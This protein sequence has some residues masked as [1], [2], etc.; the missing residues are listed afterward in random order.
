MDAVAR[1]NVLAQ[2]RER[3]LEYAVHGRWRRA[4]TDINGVWGCWYIGMSELVET[5]GAAAVT[6]KLAAFAAAQATARTAA[7]AAAEQQ[8]EAAAEGAE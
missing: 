3:A 4:E 5:F 1:G 7:I 6:Q 2:P 8:P